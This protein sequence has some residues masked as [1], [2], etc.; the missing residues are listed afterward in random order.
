M[1]FGFQGSNVEISAG[2]GWLLC[3]KVDVIL[4]LLLF[5]C[6]HVEIIVMPVIDLINQIINLVLQHMYNVNLVCPYL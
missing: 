2:L 1:L 6:A 5:N 3:Q 4:L